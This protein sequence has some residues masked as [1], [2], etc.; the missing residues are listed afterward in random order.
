M[1][2]SYMLQFIKAIPDQTSSACIGPL[3]FN[4]NC[5]ILNNHLSFYGI[6]IPEIKL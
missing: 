6:F 1:D 5:G 2:E 4:F 3:T